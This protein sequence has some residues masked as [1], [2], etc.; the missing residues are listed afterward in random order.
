MKENERIK[1]LLEMLN[2]AIQYNDSDSYNEIISELK[3]SLF[4]PKAFDTKIAEK[5]VKFQEEYR[6]N[7]TK[8]DLLSIVDELL[9]YK[10]TDELG[11]PLHH[12]LPFQQLAEIANYHIDTDRYFARDGSKIIEGLKGYDKV[13]THEVKDFKINLDLTNE[14]LMCRQDKLK[15]FSAGEEVK[16]Y[17]VVEGEGVEKKRIPVVPTEK[18]EWVGTPDITIKAGTLKDIKNKTNLDY[19]I[20]VL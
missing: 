9:K 2:N 5:I 6:T 17:L 4:A 1:Y 8:D 3:Q 10:F 16:L 12:A 19:A 14:E 20:E 7:K 15:A 13:E 11:H 18:N